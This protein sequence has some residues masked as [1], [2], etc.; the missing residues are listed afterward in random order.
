MEN[1][2]LS[3]AFYT[4]SVTNAYNLRNKCRMINLDVSYLA[5]LDNLLVQIISNPKAVIIIDIKYLRHLRMISSFCHFRNRGEYKFVYLTPSMDNVHIVEDNIHA[6]TYE[7]MSELVDDLPK[8]IEAI[9]NSIDNGKNEIMSNLIAQILEVYKINPKH[10]GFSYLKDCV[11]IVSKDKFQAKSLATKV[12][13]IIAKKYNTTVKSV[14]KD[15]RF[16]IKNASA[17]HPEIYGKDSFCE[18]KITN[19]KFVMHIVEEMDSFKNNK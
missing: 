17:S 12:Y 4:K 11:E 8:M 15:I 9:N 14:E 16:T 2:K 1:E 19:R 18:G 10:I 13:S 5:D 3:I 6:Y 7:Q